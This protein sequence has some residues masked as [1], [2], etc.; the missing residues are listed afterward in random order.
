MKK[1]EVRKLPKKTILFIVILVFLSVLVIYSQSLMTQNE[2][3]E[4][5]NKIG[6][7][8]VKN[9]TVYNKSKMNDEKTKGNGKLYKIKFYDIDKNKECIGL[10][11]IDRFKK[12]KQDIDCEKKE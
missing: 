7:T 1:H 6:I 2:V 3:K 10:I 8:N 12:I 4:H 5:L 11:F 9:I